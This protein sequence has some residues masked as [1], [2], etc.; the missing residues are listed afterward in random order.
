MEKENQR[1]D[2]YGNMIKNTQP[3]IV[4]ARQLQNF[5]LDNKFLFDAK[6]LD[7]SNPSSPPVDF[8]QIV[9]CFFIPF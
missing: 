7:G 9:P 3:H 4:K 5:Y 2:I 8:K 1:M 6:I